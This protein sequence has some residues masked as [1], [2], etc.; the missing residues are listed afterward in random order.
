MSN[1]TT[2]HAQ[3]VEIVER[4]RSGQTIQQIA[5][6]M[7]LNYYT[8][9]KWW[10]SYRDGGWAGVEPQA[11]GRP[12]NGAMSTFDPTVKY[13]ALRLMRWPRRPTR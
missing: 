3:R 9:R 10:R 11:I 4:H 6:E 2:T 13:V 1:R 7:Q 5:D 8:V 12:P